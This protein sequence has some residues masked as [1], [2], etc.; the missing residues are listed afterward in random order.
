MKIKLVLLILLSLLFIT[1]NLSSEITPLKQE[2]SLTFN[3]SSQTEIEVEISETIKDQIP[4][5]FLVKETLVIPQGQN[6][7]SLLVYDGKPQIKRVGIWVKGGKRY[8]KTGLHL[9]LDL[10][11][12][13]TFRYDIIEEWV[14]YDENLPTGFL[15]VVDHSF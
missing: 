2:I 3:N 12:T 13:L 6:R 11:R 7:T 8:G 5:T 4:L 1:N 14:T 9:K 15:K 10:V